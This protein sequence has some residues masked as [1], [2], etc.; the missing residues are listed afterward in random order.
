MLSFGHPR[1]LSACSVPW[2]ASEFP[3]LASIAEHALLVPE[4]LG[5]PDAKADG[6]QPPISPVTA[7]ARSTRLRM[8]IP[9]LGKNLV[10]RLL[11][12]LRGGQITSEAIPAG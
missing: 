5:G 12:S 7:T 3:W 10:P 6:T 9:L 1:T 8:R 11:P 2:A 4:L